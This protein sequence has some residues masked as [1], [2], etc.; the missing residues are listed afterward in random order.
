[1]YPSVPRLMMLLICS[2][3]ILVPMK[4]RATPVKRRAVISDSG[5]YVFNICSLTPDKKISVLFVGTV[6]FC[7]PRVSHIQ[8][9]LSLW[10]TFTCSS[11]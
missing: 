3:T 2:D 4:H 10:R 7:I 11:L 9:W 8:L 1:M 5:S 6:C